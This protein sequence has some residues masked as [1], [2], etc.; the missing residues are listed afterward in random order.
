MAVALAGTERDRARTDDNGRAVFEHL[1]SGTYYFFAN[2]RAL[3]SHLGYDSSAI[4]NEMA[5][6]LGVSSSKP[7]VSPLGVLDIINM[8]LWD[9]SVGPAQNQPMLSGM[10]TGSFVLVIF[11]IYR[12]ARSELGFQKFVKWRA[13]LRIALMISL[14]V[15]L[16]VTGYSNPVRYIFDGIGILLVYSIACHSIRTSAFEWRSNDWFYRQNLW[17]GQCI[18]VLLAGR[19]AHK[20]YEDIVALFN[21]A[22]NESF[23]RHVPLTEYTRDPSLTSIMYIVIAYY[24]VFYVLLIRK[25]QQASGTIY[26]MKK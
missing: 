24:I 1:K 7:N 13:L 10:T 11:K 19:I 22:A 14:G 18:L 23:T 6:G 16:L 3:R 2:I 4:I 21:A 17:I 15:V 26:S 20:G 5:L 8:T 9:I 25:E 12:H